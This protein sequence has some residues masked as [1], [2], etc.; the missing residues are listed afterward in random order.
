MDVLTVNLCKS[1]VITGQQMG[2]YLMF[3]LSFK[4]PLCS[5]VTISFV[6]TAVIGSLSSDKKRV[7][8]QTNLKI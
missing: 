7:G 5:D 6:E 3:I 4:Y 2:F 8:G 1:S